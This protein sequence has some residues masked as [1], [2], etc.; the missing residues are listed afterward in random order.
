MSREGEELLL[1]TASEPEDV[2]S[3]S[4]SPS[5]LMHASC[6]KKQCTQPSR[7]AVSGPLHNMIQWTRHI[8]GIC[9]THSS[10]AQHI[11]NLLSHTGT[12]E[13]LLPDLTKRNKEYI[14]DVAWTFVQPSP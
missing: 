10:F 2:T 1:V 13:H 4:S 5:R 7:P 14:Q 3:S 12:Q 8:K 11:A 9:N 6:P